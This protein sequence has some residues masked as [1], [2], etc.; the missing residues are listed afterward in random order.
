MSCGGECGAMRVLRSM[1]NRFVEVF[2][3]PA[4]AIRKASIGDRRDDSFLM[5]RN[6]ALK[7]ALMIWCSV[8]CAW[9]AP[10]VGAVAA[11]SQEAA[12]SAQ[13]DARF[14]EAHPDLRDEWEEVDRASREL[15]A[16]GFTA[17]DIR[18]VIDVLAKRTRQM[19]SLRTPAEW[20]KKAV[21]LYPEL[22][23]KGSEFNALF[24]QHHRELQ[25]SSPVFVQEPSWPVLLAKR[26][27]DELRARR[28]ASAVPPPAAAAPPPDPAPAAPPAERSPPE[29]SDSPSTVASPQKAS[30]GVGLVL[31]AVALIVGAP[32]LG[33]LLVR[34]GHGRL[35]KNGS[36]A[37]RRASSPWHRA[38]KPATVIYCVAAIAAVI[39][40]LPANGDLSLASRFFITLCVGML[41]GGCCGVVGY[42]LALLYCAF[43][44]RDALP[45]SRPH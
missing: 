45:H 18:Q 14:F 36:S 21:S 22:G 42:L 38:L 35:F 24:V 3:V 6:S 34:W 2:R 37:E 26:C 13:G 44:P 8:L 20:Q 12:T 4:V 39:H 28:Q 40:S 43:H 29:L 41:F 32:L 31:A 10:G 17:T 25:G 15:A 11:V 19:L 16:E 27:A 23:I 33:L 5:R 30:G 7:V 1:K 9:F